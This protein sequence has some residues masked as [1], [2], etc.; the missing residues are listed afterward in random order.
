[1]SMGNLK[2]LSSADVTTAGCL[3]Q[4]G[5]MLNDLVDREAS[6]NPYHQITALAHGM[7]KA[8]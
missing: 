8:M 7:S 3:R 4:Y 2:M 1:M 6:L 5:K